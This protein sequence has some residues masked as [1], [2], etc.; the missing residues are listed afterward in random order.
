M[1]RETGRIPVVDDSGKPFVV[2]ETTEFVPAGTT[3]DPAAV[4]DMRRFYKL[5]T[6]IVVQPIDDDTFQDPRTKRKFHRQP[7]KGALS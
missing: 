7:R 6:G 2:V 3:L 5:S 1:L 4:T